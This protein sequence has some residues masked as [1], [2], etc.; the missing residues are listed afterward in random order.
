M[1]HPQAAAGTVPDLLGSGRDDA[2][3][4]A[5]PGRRPTSFAELRTLADRT[6]ESLNALGIGRN[7]RVAIVLP[8][9]PAVAS[10]AVTIACP[11]TTMRSM[12]VIGIFCNV[13]SATRSPARGVVPG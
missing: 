9:G 4:I 3:V 11:G 6:A 2:P 13:T 7:D 8:N 12:K 10:A 5:A 1:T